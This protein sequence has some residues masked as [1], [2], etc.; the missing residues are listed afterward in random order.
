[1]DLYRYLLTEYNCVE[2]IMFLL[3]VFW[4]DEKWQEMAKN[5]KND[6]V[7]NRWTRP[8]GLL[9]PKIRDEMSEFLEIFPIEN[10][11]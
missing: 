5:Y 6:N 1:M 10:Q 7:R 2:S 8:E 4:A 9:D 3:L 11:I